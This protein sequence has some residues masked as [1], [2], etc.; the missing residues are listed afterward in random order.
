MHA[1]VDAVNAY[2]RRRR[3]L[4]LRALLFTEEIQKALSDSKY[5]PRSFEVMQMEYNPPSKQQTG[6]FLN[7]LKDCHENFIPRGASG[8]CRFFADPDFDVE[9]PTPK[10]EPTRKRIKYEI[11]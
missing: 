4:E 9:P 5:M 10:S 6:G 7:S 2:L 11:P 3:K 1:H 8:S